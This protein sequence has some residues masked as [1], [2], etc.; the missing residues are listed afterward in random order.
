MASAIA[1][2]IRTGSSFQIDPGGGAA[3]SFRFA[4]GCGGTVEL[5]STAGTGASSGSTPGVS[6]S[7][8]RRAYGTWVEDPI[9]ARL[10]VFSRFSLILAF[11]PRRS[12]R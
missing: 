2:T 11:L 3:L 4:G 5:W 6:V 1:M 8:V 7:I 12:R 9:S 10:G